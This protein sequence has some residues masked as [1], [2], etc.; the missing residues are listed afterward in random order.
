MAKLAFLSDLHWEA[1]AETPVPKGRL[2]GCD[3]LLVLGDV[4]G[5]YATLWL[6][7]DASSVT[8][9]ARWWEGPTFLV[10][11][12]HEFDGVAIQPE[13]D[14]LRRHARGT[15]VQVLYNDSAVVGAGQDRVRILGTTLWTD[16]C[17]HGKQRQVYDY[18]RCAKKIKDLQERADGSRL[19]FGTLWM[20]TPRRANGWNE[21]WKTRI[22][23][24]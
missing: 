19:K 5:R 20:N 15:N 21:N 2:E 10:P 11:G 3:A 22:S 7:E 23:P 16:F 4:L 9:L 8:R 1:Q 24:R 13:L 6:G 17:L 14:R 18:E 12:N